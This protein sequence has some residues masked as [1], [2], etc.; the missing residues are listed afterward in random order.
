MLDRGDL[1]ALL[2]GFDHG[3][4]AFLILILVF[5]R[6]EFCGEAFDEL[7]GEFFLGGLGL[8]GGVGLA[9]LGDFADFVGVIH[10]VQGHAIGARADDHDVFALVHGEFGDGRVAGLFHGLEEKLV[11]FLAFVLGSDVIGGVVVKRVDFVD[12]DE[13]EDFHGPSGLRLDFVELLFAEQ[14]ILVLFVLVA[15]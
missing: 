9:I 4:H 13:F 1:L 15:L 10:G 5:F 12:L 2:L 3:A 11:G 14:D 6:L 7:L 8:G